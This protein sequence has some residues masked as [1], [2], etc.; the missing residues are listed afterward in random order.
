MGRWRK[1]FAGGAALWL[2]ALAIFATGAAGA[3]PLPLKVRTDPKLGTFLVDGDGRTL[4]LYTKDTPGV[5]NCYD[6]CA[7]AWPPLMAAD[8]MALPAGVN[9][10]L[11]TVTRKDGSKQ[12]AY[13]DPPLYYY[14]K[15][16]NPNDITGQGVGNVWFVVTTTSAVPGAPATGE[17]GMA[18]RALPAYLAPLAALGALSVLLLAGALTGR[19][20]RRRS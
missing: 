5:T 16:V 4:Y 1:W 14:V 12:I 2:V 6:Q 8:N 17:G 15:D 10:K 7:L 19:V 20:H 18:A 3:A 9:G 11:T 13:N